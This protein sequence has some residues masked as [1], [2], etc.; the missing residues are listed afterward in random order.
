[1]TERADYDTRRETLVGVLLA[2][3]VA[4][5]VIIGFTYAAAA[6]WG[7]VGAGADGPT[8]AR[9]V[10]VL[11]EPSTW[12]GLLWSVG[13]ATAATG[14]ATLGAVTVAAVFRGS[15]IADLAGRTLVALPLPL[16]HLVAAAL[17]VWILGQSGLVARLAFAAGWIKAPSDMPA[18]IYDHWGVGLVLTMA[19]KETAFLSVVATALLATRA[20]AAEET[21]R[22][23]GASP[24]ATFRRVTWPLLWRG[25]LPAV[26]SV[27]I[28]VTGSYEAAA[29]LAPSAPLAVPL[30]IADR[31]ADPDLARRGD[32]YVLSLLLLGIAVLA[33]AGHEGARA[34]WEPL[35]E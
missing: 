18:L 20:D 1:M 23:L 24:W 12:S 10:R 21:A 11:A 3:A 2:L 22:T 5:P 4:A 8:G 13:V 26:V 25:L 31:S 14:I 34:R 33:V 19:W 35:E 16:P 32:A 27:F 15:R 6:S 17:G 30:A 7:I 29:L 9:F 28:F